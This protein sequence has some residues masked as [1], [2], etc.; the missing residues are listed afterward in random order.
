MFSAEIMA[1]DQLTLLTTGEFINVH[2]ASTKLSTIIPKD[3]FIPLQFTGLL[4]KN[5][6]EIYEGDI[7]RAFD[8]MGEAIKHEIKWR[9]DL[10]AF[11][12]HQK[13]IDESKFEVIGNI[14]EN[15]ELI[16]L[17]AEAQKGA[18]CL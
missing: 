12:A 8:S 13:W 18:W 16:A 10:C 15:P 17:G 3:Q 9:Q 5:G 6:K 14:Y 1:Q 4:D 11:T 7:I 2:S